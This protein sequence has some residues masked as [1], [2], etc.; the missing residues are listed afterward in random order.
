MV[1]AMYGADAHWNDKYL[2]LWYEDNFTIMAIWY[3]QI[4]HPY[5]ARST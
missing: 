2:L 3:D 5:Y 1:C 4:S